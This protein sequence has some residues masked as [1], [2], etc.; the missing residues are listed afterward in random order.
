MDDT[1]EP[2]LGRAD[3]N[4]GN[5]GEQPVHAVQI[6]ARDGRRLTGWTVAVI[7]AAIAAVSVVWPVEPTTDA[8][9]PVP[10]VAAGRTGIVDGTPRVPCP[11]A[12]PGA[13][14]VPALARVMAACLGSAQPVDVGAALAGAPVLINV[15]ASWGAPCRN[16]MPVLD[17][18]GRSP[19]AVAVVGMD[20]Q[21]RPAASAALLADLGVG[22]P[23]FGPAD[24]VATALAAPPV[25][26][27]SYLVRADG[28]VHRI[29]GITSFTDPD[30]V[31][32][33]VNAYSQ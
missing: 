19:G 32:D 21:D 26:P 1:S 13:G 28:S 5:G 23:S 25:L 20:V 7:V 2:T 24:D 30:Q 29:S 33:A 16:E 3:E 11:H 10:S 22:Y 27:L 18:Y 15:W 6:P 31:R 14:A 8:R 4:R 12:H 17:A 9:F